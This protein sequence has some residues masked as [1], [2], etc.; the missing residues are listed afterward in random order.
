MKVIFSLIRII[1]IIIKEYVKY[2]FGI[3]TYE[4][5]IINSIDKLSNYNI[6][7]TKIYQ[8]NC[9][10]NYLTKKISLFLNKY[11]N[12][13][14]YNSN[15]IDNENLLK[16]MIHAN[17]LNDKLEILD[18]DRPTNSGS[19]SL[20]FNAKLN[21]KPVIIKILRKNIK[22]TI[23][24]GVN[25]LIFFGD[26]I[27]YIPKLNLLMVDVII[28][29]NKLNLYNQINFMNEINNLEMYHNKF[30]THKY[31]VTPYVYS[32][33]THQNNNLIIM[34]KISGK[35][36]HELSHEE[37][38]HYTLPFV[39][40]ILK[41]LFSKNILH[42]DLH[43]GNIL[44]FNEIIDDSKIYKIGIID[45]GMVFNL[46]INDVNFIYLL[47]LGIFNDEIE[48]FINYLN[49]NGDTVFEN[50][51]KLQINNC[52]NDLKN[53]Y[54]NKKIFKNVEDFEEVMDDMYLFLQ[55]IKNNKCEFDTNKNKLIL[56]IIPIFSV[57]NKLGEGEVPFNNIREQI[58]KINNLIV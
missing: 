56:A 48:N 49:N 42:G 28:K 45:M 27:K 19:I 24:D 17:K 8:W 36:I 13:V 38:N 23:I 9:N 25:L 14:P 29:K 11:G 43:H 41:S 35:H 22:N 5:V 32:E 52:T 54:F 10:K 15:D 1:F 4:D 58:C 37:L 6:I 53:K 50:S 30:L 16:L 39:K 18:I 33:Y 3:I 55:I 7:F 46:K 51:S 2:I 20:I 34:E 26:I 31:I 40:F 21:D 47:L 44:F 12:N 57:I